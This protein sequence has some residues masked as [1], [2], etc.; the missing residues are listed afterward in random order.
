MVSQD[1]GDMGLVDD[2][3]KMEIDNDIP[4]FFDE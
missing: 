4:D 2:D 3:D 1:M